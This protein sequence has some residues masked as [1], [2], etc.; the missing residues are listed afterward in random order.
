MQPVTKNSLNSA[1]G[2]KV[3]NEIISLV[4]HKVFLFCRIKK[5]HIV[6]L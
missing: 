6:T 5:L 3:W 1:D 4:T 2:F